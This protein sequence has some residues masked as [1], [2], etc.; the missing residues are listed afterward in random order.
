LLN[1]VIAGPVGTIRP[2]PAQ[3]SSDES[4]ILNQVIAEPG[5]GTT[6]KVPAPA[7]PKAP[8]LLNELVTNPGPAGDS[9]QHESTSA[10]DNDLMDMFSQVCGE[11]QNQ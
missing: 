1:Q 6:Q 9:R 3:P 11:Q 10:P 2:V 5:G 4:D 8:D 7:S